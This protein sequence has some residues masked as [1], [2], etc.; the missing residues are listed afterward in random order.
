M[1]RYFRVCFVILL[2]VMGAPL[3]ANPAAAK[4]PQ[5]LVA[6][7]VNFGGITISN[8]QL[9]SSGNIVVVAPGAAV[10]ANMDYTIADPGCPGCVDQIE[11]V[12]ERAIDTGCLWLSDAEPLPNAPD[13]HRRS[14]QAR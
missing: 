11:I 14:A 7:S 13:A 6:P 10:G 4:T 2:L 3:A 9:N 1:P 5:Y 8:V 12:I